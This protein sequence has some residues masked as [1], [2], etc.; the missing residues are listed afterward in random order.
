MICRNASTVDMPGMFW[1]RHIAILQIAAQIGM[2]MAPFYSASVNAA[3]LREAEDNAFQN[4][5]AQQVSALAPAQQSKNLNGYIT[6]QATGAA[7]QEMQSWLQNF[8]TAR[9]EL[10]TRENF[11]FNSGAVDLLTPLSSS[12]TRFLFTQ[13]GMRSKEGQITG[14]FGL[15]QRHFIGDWMLGY[16][17]FY[18]LNF[19]R[20]HQRAGIGAEAWRDYLKLSGNGYYRL[21]GWKTSKDVEDY[22]ER[23][24][25]G[26]DVRAEAYLPALPSLG[27]KLMY[28][29]YY[30]NE[31][32][33]FGTTNRQSNPGAVTAGLSYTPVPLVTL[34]ADHKRGGNQFE[35]QFGLQLN[36]QLGMSW[37]KH[38]DTD[39]VGERRT[40]AGSSRDLVERN[41][42]IILDYRKKQLVHF[43][44]PKEI[45]GMSQKTVPVTYDLSAK[46]GLAR[47]KWDDA[48]LRAAGGAITELVSGQYQLTLPPYKVNAS[49]IYT[50]SAVAID[51]RNN[52][53]PVASTLVTVTGPSV[54]FSKS[55][56][57]VSPEI[58]PADGISSAVVTVKLV[59]ENGNPVPGMAPA[60]KADLAET[61]LAQAGTMAKRQQA[62][63]ATLS[64][65]TET[66]PGVYNWA[67]TAG[68]RVAELTFTPAMEETSFNAV[69]IK[70]I[71]D[72]GTATIGQDNFTL[73]QNESI[74][75]G[76]SPNR[77]QAKVTDKAGNPVAGV[78]V[79]F[80][81]S[82]DA[83]PLEG[84]TLTSNA[85][86][87]AVLSFVNTVAETVTV[88][89]VIDHGKPVSVESRFLADP[90]TAALSESELTVD[91]IRLIAN[92]QEEATFSAIA[93][94]AQGNPV[95]NVSVRWAADAGSL[96]AGSVLT[97]SSGKAQV[98]LK[99]TQAGNIQVTASANGASAFAPVVLFIADAGS[100]SIGSDD[101]TADKTSAIADGND[102]ISFT[103][104][105]KDAQGNPVPD[106]VLS[107]TTTRGT[108]SGTS[109]QTDSNG[110]SVIRLTSK[111]AGGAQVTVRLNTAEYKAPAVIFNADSNSGVI[112]KDSITADKLTEVANGSSSVTFMATVKDANG[113]PVPEVMVAWQTSRGSLSAA[114]SKTNA[115]GVAIVSLTSTH[116][117]TAQVTAS[118]NGRPGN[119]PLI[120]F[121]ADSRS[122]RIEKANFTRD[123]SS[124]VANGIEGIA[125]TAIVTDS[126]SNP[127]PQLPVAWRTSQGSLSSQSSVTNEKGEA[128]VILSSTLAG[129]SVVTATPSEGLPAQAEAVNFVADPASA[130]ISEQDVKVDFASRLAD[131]LETARFSVT[132]KD[133]HGNVV[134][135]VSVRWTTSLGE[136]ETAQSVTDGNGVATITLKSVTAGIAQVDAS[137]RATRTKAP[138]VNFR[139]DPSTGVIN[140]K[141]VTADKSIALANGEEWITFSTVVKDGNNNLLEGQTVNWATSNGVL[142]SPVSTTNTAGVATVRLKSTLAGSAQVMVSLHGKSASAPVVTFT[143]DAGSGE[144][145]EGDLSADKTSLLANGKA[146]ATFKAIVKDAQGNLLSGQTVAWSTNLGT[147]STNTSTTD[148]NGIASVALKSTVAA[149]AQLTATLRGKGVKAPIVTFTPD[150]GS[151]VIDSKNLTADKDSAV[152]NGAETV[153]FNAVVKDAGGN[154]VPGVAVKWQTSMGNLSH[155]ESITS[156]AGIATVTLKS[157][158]SGAAQVT[159]S[160]NGTE[161]RAPLVL[162]NADSSSGGIGKD[163]ITAS[164]L[165]AVANG[166]DTI[167]VTAIVKDAGGNLVPGV[168]VKWKTSQGSLSADETMTDG[169]GQAVVALKSVVAGAAQVSAS[170]NNQNT[171][172][173]D[174]NFIADSSSAGIESSDLSTDKTSALANGSE[175]ITFSA[176]VKDA[177]GNRVPGMKVNWSTSQGTL[178]DASSVTDTSG[179]AK[180]DL[181][182]TQAGVA[183]VVARVSGAD[184]AAPAVTFVADAASGAIAK[185][186]LSVNKITLIA[187]GIEQATY[188][189]VVKDGNGNSVA[190]SVVS[191]S[192]T[193]GNLSAA[194]STTNAAGL[195]TVTITSVMAGTAQVSASVNS[196]TTQAPSVSFT[197]D[198]K[199]SV[200]DAK[201]LKVDKATL[202]A[203]GTEKA[204][205]SVIVRDANG[206]VVPGIAVSWATTRGTLNNAS[207]ISDANGM[208]TTT[209][210]STI[211]G[212]AQ[213]V[214]TLKSNRL[215]APLVTFMADAGTR[216]IDVVDAD[217]LIAIADGKTVITF[218]ALVK[219]THGNALD[220]Q[221]V[222]WNTSLGALS[223][224]SSV[225]DKNGIALVTLTAVKAGDAVVSAT[226]DAKDVTSP[227]VTFIADA[228]S[229]EIGN[230]AITVDKTS[231]L[232]NGTEQATFRAVVRDA[233]GNL[234]PDVLVNWATSLGSLDGVSSLTDDKGTAVMTLTSTLAGGAQVSAAI[235]GKAT[236]AKP[237]TFVADAGSAVIAESDLKVDQVRVVANDVAMATY[238]AAVK[239][240]YGNVLT[241]VTV[242]WSTSRG[243][244]S[245]ATSVTDGSGMASVTLKSR[246]AGQTQ[247][248]AGLNGKTT[249]APVINFIGDVA[250][251][252]L[253][254]LTS[255]KVKITGTGSDD[256]TMTAY[257]V[258]ANSNPVPDAAVSWS[259]SL[260][261][262]SAV[263]SQT[264]AE[265]IATVTLKGV[266]HTTTANTQ[267][268]VTAKTVT[269][270]AVSTDVIVRAVIHVGGRYYWTMVSDFNTSVLATA[271]NYCSIYGGGRVLMATD[272]PAFASAGGDFKNMNVPNP[273]Y[274]NEWIRMGGADWSKR[275]VDL[276]SYGTA[277]GYIQSVTGTQYA[278]IK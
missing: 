18:D 217:R 81:L 85:K 240:A 49:N 138:T 26:F 172:A 36:Y 121:S 46:Y 21:S 190:G 124:A 60:L 272:V 258:D 20:G 98:R 30:G 160:V 50:L 127:V 150:A 95:Q 251:A 67:L 74:A 278:C 255:D 196:K 165:T 57:T 92:G 274:S 260:S 273:E 210:Q 79:N 242:N 103:A 28:E 198:S 52:H 116:A 208:A 29:K 162:F 73:T 125:Y 78:A 206:N 111:E 252:R 164:K 93:R 192:A 17:A 158:L 229:G 174:V 106:Q 6:Q 230:D 180:I 59:D 40:L 122:A 7:A 236:N 19:N 265:G 177:H 188:S 157:T 276:H 113:N 275:A 2:A 38:L 194:Q 163:D 108:L 84:L 156:A 202:L 268:T 142:S 223:G 86:G 167:T 187:D 102:L 58:I 200:I 143:A 221:T 99:H 239:D 134:P 34:S 13:N 69:V 37:D 261:S 237:I 189:A 218:S 249:N 266:V 235:N 136:L 147:L 159:G 155:A 82:G 212:D 182:S 10:G 215:N 77:V 11:S 123:K 269:G 62:K 32:A 257:V 71:A 144:I 119:A 44:L 22:D 87:V 23:V 43:R 264:N 130:S 137:V 132:V 120:T 88:S 48:V 66:E 110:M 214:V 183:N 15:G 248:T 33:L 114:D 263:K 173:P 105:V 76:K 70:Q 45:T 149:Q 1:A 101:I 100:G 83:K 14:N 72:S 259:T 5:L 205:F 56:V 141:D 152:A 126:H 140:S 244:L 41:N 197:A 186:D 42:N 253:Q 181:T 171:S 220:A 31:V 254:T 231:L 168:A 241:G 63:T 178:S 128:T 89:A 213:V 166:L 179:I 222:N 243:N 151:A 131:G 133:A 61:P 219:D 146:V 139:A 16:N 39:L 153:T 25:N 104:A 267:A 35:T 68:T 27:G 9:V 234:V 195:A 227:K 238:T 148:S 112:G 161:A 193:L 91:K 4:T 135:G 109:S 209:L 270:N 216:R 53:S 64:N 107:W 169:A 256:A 250:T 51:K 191:W 262:L 3:L 54:D 115:S 224:N 94:D 204:L 176:I 80:T 207:S 96:S 154:L 129:T 75:N 271:E 184:V 225:S 185:D 228:A 145:A 65:V 55:T 232:A 247:V 246:V 199:S 8:G 175:Q 118:V 97:D 24:A 47:I 170:I 277:V 117:G 226:V 90:A 233:N 203:D 245:A 211:A 201:D 12:E